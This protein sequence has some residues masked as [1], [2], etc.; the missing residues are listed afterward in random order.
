MKRMLLLV[1]AAW[2]MA[3]SPSAGQSRDVRE[4]DVR[5]RELRELQADLANL[6]EELEA[7]D[8]DDSRAERF[9]ERAEEIREETIYLKVKMRHHQRD[10][11]SGTGLTRDEVANLRA[12]IENLREDMGAGRRREARDVRLDEGTEIVVR[13][14]DPLSSSTARQED[15]FEA[16][17]A[18]PVRAGSRLALAAG[19]RLRG[20]VTNVEA[21]RRPSKSG[22][23]ELDFDTLYIDRSRIDLRSRVVSV[24]RGDREGRR[25]TEQ[26]AGLGAIL[27]GVVGGILGGKD[28]AIIGAVV[29]GGGAVAATKGDDV[30]L[31]AGTLVTLRLERPLTVPR[32]QGGSRRDRNRDDDLD[33]DAERPRRDR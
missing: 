14:D 32:A 20:I 6:D 3:V 31:P 12:S 25:T 11:G 2:L 4:R 23:L 21:A 28:L 10:G 33:D 22:R 26:K 29:G 1:G 24:E 19:T 30:E 27:G 7:L 5:E 8:A 13:L 17:V 18:E 9:R 16:S 15:R